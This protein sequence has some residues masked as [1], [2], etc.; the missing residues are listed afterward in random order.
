[1]AE[2][3]YRSMRAGEEE[4]LS[5]LVMRAFDE[6]VAP[7][8]PEEGRAR[9]KDYASPARLGAPERR[10]DTVVAVSRRRTGGRGPHRAPQ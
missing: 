4:A 10:Q 7:D 6:F 9:F 3:T 2:V 5:R 1:M 8:L